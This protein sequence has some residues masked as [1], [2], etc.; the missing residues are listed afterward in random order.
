MARRELP[1]TTASAAAGRS[2]YRELNTAIAWHQSQR[3]ERKPTKTPNIPETTKSQVYA[4]PWNSS[5]ESQDSRTSEQVLL[6]RRDLSGSIFASQL[7]FLGLG[8]EKAGTRTQPRPRLA[9]PVAY[10]HPFYPEK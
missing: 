7:P 8:S 1:I 5:M 3:K 2:R 9:S 6:V 4:K 10:T